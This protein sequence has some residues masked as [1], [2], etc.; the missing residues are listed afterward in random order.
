MYLKFIKL[1]LQ[2]MSIFVI[3]IS[4]KE[5]N[6]MYT[7]NIKENCITAQLIYLINKSKLHRCIK[8]PTYF[9]V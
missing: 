7:V 3:K 5:I 1:K 4:R 2:L 6:F 9:L 8:V